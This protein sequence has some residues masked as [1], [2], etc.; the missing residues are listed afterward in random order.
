MAWMPLW[1]F[2]SESGR[3]VLKEWAR[4]ARLATRVRARLDQKL[5]VLRRQSFE[6]LIHTH[7]LAGP[8]AKQLHIY[9]LRV[10]G[11]VAVRVM[12]CRGPLP[13]EPGYTLLAGALER[14]RRLTP[15]DAP[16]RATRNRDKVISD[17]VHRRKPYERFGTTDD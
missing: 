2:V 13:G 11:Q 9:K 17:P 8:I 12:L 5:D 14:D 6:I 7:L 4:E 1:T 15:A 16:E 3:D 10:D